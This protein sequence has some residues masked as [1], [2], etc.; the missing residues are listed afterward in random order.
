L[1]EIVIKIIKLRGIVQSLY[2]K[3]EKYNYAKYIFTIVVLSSTK[4]SWMIFLFG[5]YALR[6]F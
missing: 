2:L 5:Y 3:D 1:E 4:Y 6:W